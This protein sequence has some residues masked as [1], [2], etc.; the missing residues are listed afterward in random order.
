MLTCHPA[1]TQVI[2]I[3][4]DPLGVAGDL[5]WK[6]GPREVWAGP[7]QGGDRA[8]VL[9]NRH[10]A[11]PPA[12]VSVDWQWLGYPQGTRARVRDC[13]AEEN[14]GTYVDTYSA[15]LDN[16]DVAI[17]RVT[18]LHPSAR[19]DSW[20]PWHGEGPILAQAAVRRAS[21]RKRA[22][23]HAT[24]THAHAPAVV[25][26]SPHAAIGLAQGGPPDMGGKQGRTAST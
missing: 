10:T 7:L 26:D 23:S 17:L 13:F 24:A 18:P 16:A 8:V 22:W 3:N 2:N 9:F 15:R 19:Y 25:R 12:E 21:A 1:F 14:L 5:I 6:Q 4:Q 11:G 20:R